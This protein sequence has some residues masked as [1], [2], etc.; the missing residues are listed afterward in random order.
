M[1]VL[2]ML[3]VVDDSA[4]IASARER[5]AAERPCVFD[6]DS[7]D[8]TVCGLRHA[9]RHRV[10]FVVHDPGEPR[11]EGVPAERTRLLARST[12][13]KDLSPFLV[14]G[15]QAGVTVGVGSDGR[16]VRRKPAP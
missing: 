7:T 5:L 14:G 3:A 12:P 1:F 6:P 8:I 2:L 13:V 9:D 15:G 4:L 16:V 10:P 11:H